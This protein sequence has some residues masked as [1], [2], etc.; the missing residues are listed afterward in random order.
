MRPMT[1]RRLLPIAFVCAA[2]TLPAQS[3]FDLGA[4]VAPQFHS[5][6]IKDPTNIKISEFSVPLFVV[7]PVTPS[8]GFD[9][10]TSWAQSTVDQTGGAT[11]IRSTISGL[12]DT[13]VRANYVLGNDFIVLTAG[14]NIPTGKSTVPVSEQ[15]AAG[16]IGSDFLAFP[17]ASMGTGFGGTG[18]IAIAQPLGDWNF[19]VGFSVRRSAQY[20]PFDAAGGP[21]LHY[22]PG[23]EYRGRVGL[24][25][26]VGTGRFT[27]GLTYSQFGDDKLANSIYNTG[28]RYLSQL[29]YND[30]YGP[31]Q[32][33]LQSWDLFRTSGHL[34]DGTSIGHENIVN[35]ALAYGITSGSVIIEPNVEA[36]GWMQDAAST[37]VMGTVG[38]RLQ[39]PLAGFTVVPSAGYSL[40]K[41]ASQTGAGVNTTAD[42]TGFHGTLAI[43]LR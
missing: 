41:L 29:S 36:R 3:I 11:T 30:T 2:S 10:G 37:S 5:Y 28:N 22:Q 4:R 31:G 19:G 14:V 20:D 7:V 34:A 13:Q 8:F 39:L 40:G 23:N 18:G 24:D 1:L 16:L 9:V 12:T 17:I 6:T 35:G 21:L 32:L 33:S 15:V 43:R 38:L 27:V 42:L 26:G 25:R